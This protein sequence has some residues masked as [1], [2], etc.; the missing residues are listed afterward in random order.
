[1]VH[2]STVFVFCLSLG[3]FVQSF[4]HGRHR[5]QQLFDRQI[6]TFLQSTTAIDNF[7]RT[8]T[9]KSIGTGTK[10]NEFEWSCG[11][12]RGLRS[13]QP[14]RAGGA[15][16]ELPVVEAIV[17]PD[18]VGKSGKCPPGMDDVWIASSVTVRVALQLLKEWKDDSASS[19]AAYIGAL[20]LPGEF[21]TPLHWPQSV[22]DQFPYP[23]L[24]QSVRNQKSRLME[25]YETRISKSKLFQGVSYERFVWAVEVVGSRAFKG[26]GIASSSYPLY[27]G[28][29]AVLVGVSA[30]LSTKN[31]IPDFLP[32]MLAVAGTLVPLPAVLQAMESN[33][34]LLPAIDS[35]NH[36][37]V[38]AVCDISLDPSKGTI[39]W[40]SRCLL[41]DIHTTLYVCV[42]VSLYILIHTMFFL[43]YNV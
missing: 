38:G 3:L 24:S 13:I 7:E 36:R 35:C 8:L 29:S 10:H 12:V 33:C 26:I 19:Y 30:Y 21:G 32:L 41:K 5:N 23:Y 17:A 11:L 4:Q 39:I 34:V 31:G 9:A 27:G 14:F 18:A 42:Y 2:R 6:D 37:G 25:L 20:P 22:L 40:I 43:H 15:V 16:V 28:I 1:M